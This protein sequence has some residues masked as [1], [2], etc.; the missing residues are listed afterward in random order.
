MTLTE[1]HRSVRRAIDGWDSETAASVRLNLLGGFELLVDGRPAR[2]PES[3]ERHVVFLALRDR[4]Q[5][6][7]FVAGNLWPEKT[8]QRALSN[9][10]SSLWRSRL[11]SGFC[12]VVLDRSYL[13]L[14]PK[15]V[16][17]V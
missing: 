15:V 1:A 12:V 13:R 8:D 4:P 7:L 14:D 9:L 17:D 2:L 16:L 10:R 11:D 6:H 3:S 5:P